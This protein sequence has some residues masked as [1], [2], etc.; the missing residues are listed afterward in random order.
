MKRRDRDENNEADQKG[1]IDRYI[2]PRITRS[3]TQKELNRKKQ[4]TQ[5][6]LRR[7]SLE[8]RAQNQ[9]GLEKAIQI[10]I[11]NGSLFRFDCLSIAC[12]N[13]SCNE[14]WEEMKKDNAIPPNSTAVE[15]KFRQF[16][17]C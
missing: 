5:E 13:K 2:C 12:S 7:V 4:V 15:V 11:A 1:P 3:V 14:L 10:V 8:K 17:K 9:T 16:H 6:S